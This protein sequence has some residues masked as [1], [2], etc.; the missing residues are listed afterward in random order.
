MK[1]EIL[2]IVPLLILGTDGTAFSGSAVACE[3]APDE[4][5]KLPGI[6][7]AEP[8]KDVDDIKSDPF[9]MSQATI[10]GDVLKIKVS[11]SGGAQ[12]HAFELYWNGLI[13][14]SFPPQT[15]LVLKH[16]ANGDNAEALITDTLEFD[17]S[18]INKPMIITI[19]TDHGDSIR[20]KY[21]EP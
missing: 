8:G 17:L 10:E 2:L 11:Y 1:R 18:A 13:A 19:K 20:V 9:K 4:K 14:K 3:Q 6:T 5:P 16:D 7:E 15:T 21:G 12:K